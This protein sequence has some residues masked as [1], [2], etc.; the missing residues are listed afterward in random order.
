MKPAWDKLMAAYKGHPTSLIAD[1]DCTAAGEP[2][3]QKNGVQ[4]YPSIKYG[5]P[6]KLKDYQ[7]GRDFDSLKTFADSNLGPKCN[8]ENLKLCKGKMKEAY[9]KYMK[10]DAK[11]LEKT[12]K[13][14]RKEVKELEDD[15]KIMKDVGRYHRKVER[16]AKAKQRKAEREAK[17]KADKE[18][19]EL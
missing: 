8:A 5:E 17:K 13:E 15:L 10:V 12:T 14:K 19:K 6:G 1:V 2:L 7:G 4:G 3:C 9:E 18:K 11:E 16:D